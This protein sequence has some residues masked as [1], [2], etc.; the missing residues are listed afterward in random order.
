[1]V[2]A[3]DEDGS[4]KIEKE[5]FVKVMSAKY[6][7]SLEKDNSKESLDDDKFGKKDSA[8]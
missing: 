8:R 6:S 1:M 7:P 3:A 5:E 2:D 4:G